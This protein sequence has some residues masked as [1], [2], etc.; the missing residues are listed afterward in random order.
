MFVLF[1]TCE[2]RDTCNCQ[3]TCSKSFQTIIPS[4]RFKLTWQ[5]SWKKNSRLEYSPSC[6][7]WLKGQPNRVYSR[8]LGSLPKLLG[9]PPVAPDGREAF[10][11]RDIPPNAGGIKK[12][13]LC[14]QAS[15]TSTLPR[16]EAKVVRPERVWKLVGNL[17]RLVGKEHQE[18]KNIV[19]FFE[20]PTLRVT[21]RVRGVLRRVA[22]PLAR[23]RVVL[24]NDR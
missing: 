3:Q 5:E 18:S 17:K 21:S 1:G 15:F 7:A 8:A 23:P 16:R 14:F 6:L 24:I 2:S 19:F 13:V 10:D 9:R 11:S 22:V 4:T 20:W 12:E